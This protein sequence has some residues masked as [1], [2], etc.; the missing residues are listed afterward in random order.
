M[1]KT[2][3]KPKAVKFTATEMM[4]GGY[5]PFV[6]VTVEGRK[7]RFLI[8]TGASKSVIDKSFYEK[9]LRRKM[10]VL[11]QETTGLHSTVMESYTGVIKKLQIGSLTITDYEIAGVDLTHVNGTYDKMEITTISGIL[12]S[13]LL[14]IHKAVID[15]GKSTVTI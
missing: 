14:K 7:C 8:D 3:R 15:Y 9:K 6:E 10:K 12:G 5:H 1:A 2:S 4:G 11:K 13:D